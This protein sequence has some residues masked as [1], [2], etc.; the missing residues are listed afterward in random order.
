MTVYSQ[1]FG[2][3]E[4][5]FGETPDTRFFFS[6]EPHTAALKKLAWMLAHNKGFA[7][8][9]GDVGT[10]KTLLCRMLLRTLS[11]KANTALILHPQ[12]QPLEMLSAIAEDFGISVTGKEAQRSSTISGLLQKLNSFFLSEAANGRKSILVIDD[13]QGLPTETLETLRL[14]SNLETETDKLLQIIL[15]AQPEIEERLQEHRLRQ[16]APRISVRTALVEL[17]LAGT[18]EYLHHRIAVAGG[19]NLARFDTKAVKAIFVASGGVPRLINRYAEACMEMAEA[20]Q[21]HLIGANLVREAVKRDTYKEPLRRG[22][23]FGLFS[24]ERAG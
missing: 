21:W 20:K 16:V 15:I 6:A 9:T 13:A 10:G 14:L 22:G 23:L 12:L 3:K 17:D 1:F 2:L 8:L 5:P 18:A 11:K 4:N 24:G 7:L 19:A